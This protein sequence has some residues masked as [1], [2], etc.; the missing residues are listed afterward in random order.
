[1]SGEGSGTG[2]RTGKATDRI[3]A[4]IAQ[5]RLRM[6]RSMK[7]ARKRHP[8]CVVIDE[9]LER[10][11]SWSSLGFGDDILWTR[12]NICLMDEG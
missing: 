12:N 6:H 11:E 8:R 2:E 1:M 9:E 4:S 10:W 5:A 3:V 7:E